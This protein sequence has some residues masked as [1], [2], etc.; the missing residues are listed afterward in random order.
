[1]SNRT[2]YIC[3]EFGK[4]YIGDSKQ[5]IEKMIAAGLSKRAADNAAKLY[6]KYGLS[7]FFGRSDVVAVLGIT[8]TPASTLLKKMTEAGVTEAVSGMGK[9][10][11]RFAPSLLCR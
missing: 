11:V 1:M 4:Q 7:A 9:G 8:V 5:Y 6:A 3:G 2:M 10:K